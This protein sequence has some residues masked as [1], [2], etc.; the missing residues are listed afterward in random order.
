[1]VWGVPVVVLSLVLAI[2]KARYR[3]AKK[4][5]LVMAAVLG[6]ILVLTT[7]GVLSFGT[8]AGMIP[9]LYSGLIY[10][11]LTACLIFI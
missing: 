5:W 2:V 9:N 11:I 4:I 3:P 7:T 8:A 10:L 6:L 1:M